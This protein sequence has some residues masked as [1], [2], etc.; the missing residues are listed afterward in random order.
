MAAPLMA[1]G[2]EQVRLHGAAVHRVASRRPG[3]GRPAEG[4]IVT[5]ISA[6]PWAAAAGRRIGAARHGLG[7][8]GPTGAP[9]RCSA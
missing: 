7:S 6:R 8:S 4:P 5:G 3:R 2:A 1:H 9:R